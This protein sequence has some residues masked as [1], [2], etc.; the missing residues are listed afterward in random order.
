[1]VLYCKVVGMSSLLFICFPVSLSKI[2]SLAV[3]VSGSTQEN[4]SHVPGM[5]KHSV[6]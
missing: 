5:G 3:T 2:L 4:N 6:L 1:M